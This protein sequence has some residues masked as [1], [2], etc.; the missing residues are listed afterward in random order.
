MGAW[1][2]EGLTSEDDRAVGAHDAWLRCELLRPLQVGRRWK[3]VLGERREEGDGERW[4][5]REME[6]RMERERR[7]RESGGG[8]KRQGGRRAGDK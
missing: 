7:G 8:K 4:V 6:G 1:G 2:H 3:R 5:E